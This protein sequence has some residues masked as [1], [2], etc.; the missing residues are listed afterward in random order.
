ML[1]YMVL[2]E[3]MTVF[4]MLVD[5]LKG[6]EGYRQYPYTCT[7]GALSVGY[8]HNLQAKGLTRE[9]AEMVLQDDVHEVLV[10]LHKYSFFNALDPVRQTVLGN[11]AFNLGVNGLFRFRKMIAAVRLGNF[12]LAASE[13]LDSLWAKQVGN[14]AIEL[15][16]LMKYG[17]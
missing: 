4:H 14:R 6:H 9:Q 7:G 1:V 11:M 17:G 12:D 5:Q 15:A 13:M 16:D 2:V 3:V 8:G 10:E